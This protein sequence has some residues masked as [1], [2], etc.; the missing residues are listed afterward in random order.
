VPVLTSFARRAGVLRPAFGRNRVLLAVRVVPLHPPRCPLRR[1]DLR[2]P[3]AFSSCWVSLISERASHEVPGFGAPALP[4]ASGSEASCPP[5]RSRALAALRSRPAV[6]SLPP[7]PWQPAGE[8]SAETR[9]SLP[10]QVTVDG[11]NRVAL[12]SFRGGLVRR[13]VPRD[14]VRPFS[15]FFPTSACHATTGRGSR[16]LPGSGTDSRIYVH[17]SPEGIGRSTGSASIVPASTTTFTDTAR[18]SAPFT[19]PET[20]SS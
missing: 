15:H 20:Y 8:P 4:L 13:V 1:L 14:G 16:R 11:P 3:R 9:S 12:R 7:P 10:V 6:A 17:S 2:P 19:F 18:V 5:G